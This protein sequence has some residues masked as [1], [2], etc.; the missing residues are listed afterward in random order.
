MSGRVRIEKDGAIGWIVF[1][2]PARRNA[3]SAAMWRQIP[4]VAEALGKDDD[5][6][7]VVM[8]G[9]GET[10]FVA[11]AD[12]SEFEQERT[13]GPAASEYD[14]AGSEAYRAM[15]AIEKPTIAMIHGFCVGGGVAMALTADLRFAS[16]DARFA[17]PAARLG[18][19]YSAGLL[20]PLLRLVGS[21]RALEILYTARRYRA[22][23]ALA[24]GLVNAVSP[25]ATLESLVRECADR[26][27]ANAPLTL[28]G[29]KI[30]ARELARDPDRRDL[31]RVDAA[32]RAC[33]ESE[34]YRE[35][36]RAF[37]EKRKPSF[38]GR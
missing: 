3:I 30:A 6:R 24:M 36:V 8:R 37:M 23:E 38:K 15:A 26:I 14:R 12:I 17:V 29:V 22:D 19:G 31:S 5:V 27:A 25:K 13:G 1:D 2:H 20:E 34:D 35:G 33:F 16:D 32:V 9:E 21:A 10:A 7:V 28:R 4:E 11:G 18:L